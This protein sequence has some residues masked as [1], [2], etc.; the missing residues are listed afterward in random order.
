EA[1]DLC[2]NR[3]SILDIPLADGSLDL[4]LCLDV[5]EHIPLAD[6]RRAVWELHRVLRPGGV[7]LATIPNLAH[8]A[9]RLRFLVTGRLIR[10]STVEHHPGDRPFAEWK[11]LLQERFEVHRAYGIFPTFPELAVFTHC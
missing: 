4:V 3:G 9:S 7:M 6:H 2:I 11:A 5:I 1:P 10:T 8:L